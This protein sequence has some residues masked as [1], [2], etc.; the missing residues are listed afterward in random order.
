MAVPYAKGDKARPVEVNAGRLWAGGLATA[1]VAALVVIVG[2][3]LAR[4][5]FGV[6]VLAPEGDG[7]WGDADTGKYAL[8]AA[9]AALLATGLMHL[10]LLYTPR[11]WR[12]FGWI[13]GLATFGAVI[14]PFAT[15]AQTSAKFATATINLVLGLAIGSL[16]SGAA[17]SA[18]RRPDPPSP[19]TVGWAP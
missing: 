14:A 17:R 3:L 5:V 15:N 10:L 11:P 4:G 18:A 13:V 7:A 6:P 1:V 19:P 8:Y 2:I 16:V 12:F 9:L